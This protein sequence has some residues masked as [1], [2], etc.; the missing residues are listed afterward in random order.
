MRMTCGVGVR[1]RSESVVIFLARSIPECKFDVLS[2]D[3]NVGHIIFEDCGDVDLLLE[4]QHRYR[5]SRFPAATDNG[6]IRDI[7][8]Q[9][10]DGRGS[11]G[12]SPRGKCLC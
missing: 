10:V 9:G 5:L 4:S 6:E 3:F 2:I 11:D 7:G 8:K 12:S 1:E